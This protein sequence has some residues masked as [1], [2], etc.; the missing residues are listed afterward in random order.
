MPEPS[1]VDLPTS[2]T[3]LLAES[4]RYVRHVGRDRGDEV[5]VP[6]ADFTRRDEANVLT[7][8]AFRGGFLEHLHSG[9]PGFSD[10]EMR[11][12]MIESSARLAQALAARDAD[13]ELYAQ[14]L[15]RYGTAWT[16]DWE[17]VA[18]RADL[19]YQHVVRCEGCA[20]DM[21]T[22]WKVCASCGHHRAS[23]VAH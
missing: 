6:G 23:S 4:V 20:E 15:V 13:P 9:L 11:K 1:W 3:G 18:E 17:R 22:T 5:V 8:F 19:K 16:A 2:S 14:F 10:D 21:R 12:L 7:A